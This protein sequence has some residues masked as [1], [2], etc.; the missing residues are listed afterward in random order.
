MDLIFDLPETIARK[1]GLKFI[2][3]LDEFQNLATFRGYEAFEKK[4]RSVWQRQKHVT[5]CLYGSKRHMMA[6]IFNNPSKPFYRFGDLLFL[7]K[8]ALE[9]WVP[10]IMEGFRGSGKNI[11]ESDAAQIPI[12]MKNHPWYVQQLAH[13]TWNATQYSEGAGPSELKRALDELIFANA[14]F[15]EKEVESLSPTRLN[16]LKAIANGETQLSSAAVI[17]RYKLGTPRNA[18]KN[19][20][21]L[22]DN[23]LIDESGGELALLDPAFERWFRKQYFGQDWGAGF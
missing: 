2:I 20:K 18:L 6:E 4:M 1:K 9:K 13:Y 7:E 5:Y 17:E 8:I 12:M 23:D 16:L 21:I 22:I 10:F 3:C 14:P 19:K 11:S 15:Y